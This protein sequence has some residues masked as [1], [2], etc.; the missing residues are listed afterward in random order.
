MQA[1]SALILIHGY[2]VNDKHIATYF[3]ELIGYLRERGH[4]S[5]VV[6]FDWPSSGEHYA[7]LS[8]LDRVNVD[9]MSY[10]AGFYLLDRDSAAAVG[11]PAL[12]SLTTRIRS[13][14]PNCRL[15][16]LAH[17]MGCL[18]VESA[19]RRVTRTFLNVDRAILVAPDLG[20]GTLSDSH[21]QWN[22]FDRI[23][24]LH[25]RYDEAFQTSRIGGHLGRDGPSMPLP[26]NARTHDATDVLGRENVHM[27]Y[28]TALGAAAV[29][30]EDLLA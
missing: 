7:S 22:V 30:L 14:Q 17:S 29:R 16:I 24:V 18:V 26:A 19:L 15:T 4:S 28:L 11:A 5:P 3:D 6:V 9:P 10:E 21:V 1:A 8:A 27:K 12:K 20:V 25:S 23:D 13:V 2:G